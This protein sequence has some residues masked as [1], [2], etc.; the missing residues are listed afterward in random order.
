MNPEKLNAPKEPKRFRELCE[1]VGLA[2]MLGQKVHFALSCYYSVFHVTHGTL[3]KERAKQKLE[4][5]LSTPMGNVINS[6]NR[7]AP[8]C[9]GITKRILEFK[10]RRNWLAHDFDQEATPFLARGKRFDH[11]ICKMEEIATQACKI[12]QE[13][14]LIGEKLVKVGVQD[15]FK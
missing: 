6:I 8:L 14:H 7:E 10:D 11:Y 2:L 12:M 5:H 4:K 1:K 3:S 13:L 15:R 9:P